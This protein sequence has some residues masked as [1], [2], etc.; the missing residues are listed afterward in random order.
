MFSCLHEITQT[1][2]RGAVRMAKGREGKGTGELTQI[3]DLITPKLMTSDQTPV[4]VQRPFSN[5]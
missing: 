1:G 4:T 5:A 2:I 3:G